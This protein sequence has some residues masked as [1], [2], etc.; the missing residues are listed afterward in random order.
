MDSTNMQ[1]D[2]FGDVTFQKPA[3]EGKSEE[4]KKEEACQNLMLRLPS[5]KVA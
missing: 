5:S 2:T 4:Q 3:D 1:E